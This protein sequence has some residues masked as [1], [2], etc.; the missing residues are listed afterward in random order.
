MQKS[1]QKLCKSRPKSYAKVVQKFMQKSS[2]KL[3]K[4]RP[5]VAQKS[6]KTYAKVVPKV[7]QQKDTSHQQIRTPHIKRTN[8][9]HRIKTNPMTRYFAPTNKNPAYKT[10]ESHTQ[11]EKGR[12]K[13]ATYGPLQR[14]RA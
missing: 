1:S 10:Y 2:Q 11:N 5:K 12:K 6:H 14:K 4:S 9:I 7:I 8:R 13:S 3:C